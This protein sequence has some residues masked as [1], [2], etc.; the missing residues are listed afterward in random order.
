VVTGASPASGAPCPWPW[1]KRGASAI[2]LARRRTLLDQVAAELARLSPDSNTEVCDVGDTDAYRATLVRIEDDRGRIDVLINNAGI[3]F[4]LEA[5][6]G[7]DSVV[8][9][10]FDVISLVRSSAPW[11]CCLAWSNVAPASW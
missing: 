2:G 3:D 8:R 9:R 7:E 1:P 5:S 11:P 4:M 10:V 6:R